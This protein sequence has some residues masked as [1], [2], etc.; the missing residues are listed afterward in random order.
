MSRKRAEAPSGKAPARAATIAPPTGWA[1]WPRWVLVLGGVL[2]AVQLALAFLWAVPSYLCVDEVIYH[3]MARD[4][5]VTGS[6]ALET[7]TSDLPNVELIHQ[8]FMRFRGGRTYPQY[9]PLFAVLAGPFYGFLGLRSL[10]LL[11]ALAFLGVVALT[12]GMTAR[13]FPDRRI[14]ALAAAILVF[15]SFSWDY[16]QMA[17]SHATAVL[18]TTAAAWLGLLALGSRRPK[19]LVLAGLAGLTGGL[20]VAVRLDALPVLA[21]LAVAFLLVARPA[22][23]LEAAAVLLGAAPALLALSAVNRVKFDTL[24]PFSYG[25]SAHG[26][27][28]PLPFAAV[29]V[30]ALGL[31]IALVVSRT[32]RSNDDART[33]WSV[34][35]AVVAIVAAGLAPACVRAG[36][37]AVGRSFMSNF[38]ESRT[39]DAGVL[40]PAMARTPD[41]AVVY[42]GA[43]KKSVLQS[44]PYL[45]VFAV[46]AVALF[47]RH[48]ARS[49]LAWLFLFPAGWALLDAG[50]DFQGGLCLNMRYFLPALPFTSIL[51]AWAVFELVDRAR[52]HGVA[53]WLAGGGL[54][55]AALFFSSVRGGLP[56]ESLERPLLTLPLVLA[57]LLLACAVTSIAVGGAWRGRMAAAAASC[58]AAGLVWSGLVAF[59]YDVPHHRRQRE[60]NLATGLTVAGCI[61]PG[62]TLFTAPYIDPV[63]KVLDT[64]GVWV[65]LPAQDGFE[66]FP[67]VLQGSLKRGRRTFALFP[68][69]LWGAVNVRFLADYA[70]R[71]VRAFDETFECGPTLHDAGAWNAASGSPVPGR[72][73]LAEITRRVTDGPARAASPP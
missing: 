57:G 17:W 70:V 40:T 15:G 20:G 24:S 6:L 4:F 46:P 60:N 64:P 63:M 2:V 67:A 14:A 71:P 29:G 26:Y 50:F 10:I 18:F 7:G 52:P 72:F 65:A 30:A 61:P 28:K 68:T 31:A 23:V 47:A 9:P 3:Q 62:T 59:L 38:V 42:I 56:I 35:A 27:Q 5:A 43:L 33:R 21:A 19:A 51:A 12:A 8:D 48:G 53:R 1:T 36:L 58:A 41:G 37:P 16:S 45:A 32:R 34:A 39:L 44:L 25:P 55:A 73:V 49:T 13:A 69:G 54:A 66:G 11:N 22:R